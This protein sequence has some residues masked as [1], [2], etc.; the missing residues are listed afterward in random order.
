VV[1]EA[2]E[3]DVVDEAESLDVADVKIDYKF[4]N[5]TNL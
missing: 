1:D 2:G 4:V 5:P 3:A